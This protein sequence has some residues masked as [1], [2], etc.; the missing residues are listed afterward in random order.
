MSSTFKDRDMNLVLIIGLVTSLIASILMAYGRIFRTKH[1]IEKES[2]SH[3]EGLNKA[4]MTHRLI[5]T[6]I[7]QLGAGLL[8]L[9]FSIQIVAHIFF[10]R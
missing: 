1:T 2:N 9:G 8:I 6:R 10:E 5:E 4:E 3:T 7:A